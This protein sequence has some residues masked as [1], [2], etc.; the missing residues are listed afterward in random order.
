VRVE[1]TFNANGGFGNDVEVYL[2]SDDEFVNWQNGHP[3]NAF[4]SSGRITQGTIDTLLP[5]SG[6]YH[7]VFTNKFSWFS[8]KAVRASI[9]LH[10]NL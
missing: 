10:F 3:V 9:R 2:L 1:G 5:S 7:L 6:N 4:Y 8:P